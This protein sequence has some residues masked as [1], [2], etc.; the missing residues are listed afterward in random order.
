MA[1]WGPD[2]PPPEAYSRVTDPERFRPLHAMVETLLRELDSSFDVER[3]A[4]YGLDDELETSALALPTVRLT[5]RDATAA[6]LVVAFTAFPGIR[7]RAGHWCT[8]V[9][10]SCGCDAC[11]ETADD[12]ALR[13]REMV[14]N[15]VAGRFREAISLPLISV[16]LIGD[17][18]Q[19]WALWS[20]RGR[21]RSRSRI[22]G[23]RARA[24]VASVG[25]ASTDWA[26]WT[27]RPTE[28]SQ[29]VG[30]GR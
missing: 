17:G 6:P 27:R 2:G 3:T 20:Q 7:L 18:W 9:F 25:R 10:P 19:E 21:R 16:L 30:S 29:P 26:T 8:E 15:V 4:G 28:G 5:P 1:R 24:M 11:G 14:D 22:T 12:E 23:K 13:L